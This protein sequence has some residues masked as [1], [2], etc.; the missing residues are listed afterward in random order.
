[1]KKLNITLQFTTNENYND[2]LEEVK[3]LINFMINEAWDNIYE[4]GLEP[5]SYMDYIIQEVNE[6]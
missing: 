2:D 1:M 5:P 3:S 4:V 6:K